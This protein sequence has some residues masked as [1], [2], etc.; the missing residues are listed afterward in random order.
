MDQLSEL[1]HDALTPCA[2]SRPR[3]C[4]GVA[5]A[6]DGADCPAAALSSSCDL[7]GGVGARGVLC[8]AGARA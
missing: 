5:F 1:G 3:W 2:P 4:G 8:C 7:V 6:A